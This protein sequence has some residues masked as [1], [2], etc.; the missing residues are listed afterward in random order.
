MQKKY[1]IFSILLIVI[2]L[3]LV[4]LPKKKVKMD[5]KIRL[6]SITDMSRYLTADEVTHRIIEKDPAL[7]LIDLRPADQFRKFALPGSLNLHPDSLLSKSTLELFLQPGKDKVLYADA[8]LISEKAWLLF[9]QVAIKRIY[10]M[11]GGMKEWQNTILQEQIPSA[12]ASTTELDLISFRNAARQYF[13]GEGSAQVTPATNR[14]AE[15]IQVVRKAP[16]ATSGGGC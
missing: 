3:I 4:A 6:G 7:L 11:K 10:I 9:S 8:D 16:A 15:K 14:P 12:T 13:T 2:A 1:T 5:S